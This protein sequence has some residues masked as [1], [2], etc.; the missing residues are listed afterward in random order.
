MRLFARVFIR[1]TRARTSSLGVSL[2]CVCAVCVCVCDERAMLMLIYR[3]FFIPRLALLN[4]VTIKDN[5]RAHAPGKVFADFQ[6]KALMECFNICHVGSL[7]YNKLISAPAL[8]QFNLI[9]D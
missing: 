3:A 1:Q 5:V 6:S 8:L 9:S 7:G 2:C 4:D